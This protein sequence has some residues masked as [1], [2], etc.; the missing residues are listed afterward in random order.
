MAE[1]KDSPRAYWVLGH[2]ARPL[3]T[4]GDYGMVE[5]VS[6]PGVP[7]PPPHFHEDASEFF[8]VAEGALDVQV[9]GEWQRLEAGQSI[10][11]RPGQV[12]TLMNRTETPCRWVT[13]WSPRGFE[14]F[15]IDFGVPVEEGNAQME[16]ISEAT[17][18]RVQ[19]ESEKYGMK[20]RVG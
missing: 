11:L 5:I 9:D 4:V 13:G 8:Y 12:H 10:C 6:L 20:I 18:G 15:F 17:I 2:R 1:M 19:A 7:G 3:P 16:S 14:Q